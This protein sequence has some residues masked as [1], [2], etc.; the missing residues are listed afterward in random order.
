MDAKEAAEEL[1]H[2]IKVNHRDYNIDELMLLFQAAIDADRTTFVAELD[3]NI[4]ENAKLRE[5][6]KKLIEFARYVLNDASI[7][8]SDIHDKAE[9]LKLVYEAEVTKADIDNPTVREFGME[10]GDK[11]YKFTEALK[12]GEYLP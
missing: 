11:W 2:E 3:R 1:H 10:I 9:E 4:A 12:P 6:N 7:T 8:D 5:A